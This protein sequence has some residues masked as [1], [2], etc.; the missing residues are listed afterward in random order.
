MMFCF[1]LLLLCLFVMIVLSFLIGAVTFLTDIKRFK[2]D[3]DCSLPRSKMI[4]RI[5]DMQELENE[6]V[7]D[8]ENV[9]ES[10]EDVGQ[11]R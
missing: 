8:N 5:V 11:S 4:E 9:K 1:K 7:K 10:E 2:S 3:F 6:K